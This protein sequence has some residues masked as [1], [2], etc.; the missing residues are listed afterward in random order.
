M[1][2]RKLLS[3]TALQTGAFILFASAAPGYAQTTAAA[4]TTAATQTP[5][6]AEDQTTN[7]TD[8]AQIAA[9]NQANAPA[10]SEKS[11]VITGSRIRRPNLESAVPVTSI[12]GEQFFQRGNTDVGEALNDLPQLR[13]TFAQQNP[14]LGIGIAGLNL[15]DLRGLGTART[16]VLVNGRRHVAADIHNNAVSPDV[17]TIPADLIDRVDIVTGANSSVYGSDA[18]AGVVNFVLKRDFDGLQ[19]RAQGS[20]S[21]AGFGGTYYGSVLWGK[22]F[23]DGRGNITLHGEYNHENRVFGSDIPWLRTQNGFAIVDVDGGLDPSQH[24]S[25]GVPDRAFV[26]DIRSS[27]INRFGLV[28]ITQSLAVGPT[29]GVGLGGT[30]GGPSTT[31]TPNGT[32]FNCTYIFNPDGSL[33]PQTGTRMG[34]GVNPTILGG[35]GQTTR[36]D[37]LLSVFP[38]N[39]RYNFNLLAHYDVSDFFQP[40]VE[41]KFVRLETR[42]NNAGASFIQGTGTFDYRERTRLDN[43]FLDPA[44]RATIAAQLLASQCNPNLSTACNTQVDSALQVGGVIP[45]FTAQGTAGRLSANDIALI[46]NGAY[47]FI[48]ARNLLD[49][50]IRD[51]QFRRDTYRAVIGAKGTFNTDWSYEI[52]A[53]YGAFDQKT[54]TVGFLD[55]QRFMLAMDAGLDPATNTI[56][57]RSQFDANS[58]SVYLRGGRTPAEIAAEAARLDADVAACVPYNPFGSSDNSASIAYFSTNEHKTAKMRQLDLLG[59]INGDSSQLFELPGGPV[60]FVLGGEYRRETSDYRE[61]EFV[62]TDQSNDVNVGDFNPPAFHVTEAFGELNVPVLKDVPFFHELTLNAAGRYSRYQKPIKGVWTWNY[63]AEWAPI[64]DIRFRGNY[65]KSVRA[66]NASETGFPLVS[67]FANNFTDPCGT[68]GLAAGSTARL[69]ACTAELGPLLSQV[70]PTAYSLG[71]I[72]GSNPLLVPEVSHSLTLGGVLTPR[73]I[74]GFS[75]SVDYYNI[76]VEGVIVSVSAQT[77]VNN[78][79]DLPAG[80]IFCSLFKRADASGGP[81]GEAPGNIINADLTRLS[82]SLISGPQ[83]FAKRIRRGIDFNANYHVRLAPKVNLDTSLVWVHGLQSSNFEN[84][85]TPSFEN[86]LLGELGDPK[87]EGKLFADLKVGNVTFGYNVHYIG[88]MFINLAE[89]QITLPSGCTVAGDPNSCPPNNADFADVLHYPAVW[90]HGLRFQWDT[91]PSFS[92]VKNIQIY[93]GVDNV[94]NR[95]A[96][97]G[98]AATGGGI[99]GNGNAAI[100]DVMGRKYYGGVKV[101]F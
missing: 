22:N 32:P 37:R 39:N 77:I 80:N 40:F 26:R 92:M 65:G 99:A 87:D 48:T 93:A 82:D 13:S 72:S 6:P 49:V 98:L 69:N 16:L 17:N 79:Y 96:P 23:D 95:H 8:P 15:L 47:R 44:A 2:N 97:F 91:G 33:V 88:K 5:P 12:Q 71:I 35:N 68:Q 94:F 31:G 19:V 38:K 24:N 53:N 64:Q 11:I 18:I 63:G 30:N 76:K 20:E 29:C 84:P 46:N 78:C 34:V 57:C 7:S 66:P 21:E 42:G 81:A 86:Q 54:H 83:N 51:E 55:K 41:A 27:T 60:S 100:Y 10:G 58:K 25:D 70:R 73:F 85:S 14:G 75:L 61:D 1:T 50:G 62:K 45:G 36:E 59:F 89:D 90:Y 9:A 74:P 56:K 101:R 43:P 4:A 52:S 67:N 28:P 3:A